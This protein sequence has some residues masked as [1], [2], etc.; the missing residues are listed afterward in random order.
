MG[1][2]DIKNPKKEVSPE[3]V[4]FSRMAARNRDIFQQAIPQQILRRQD[5]DQV[6]L[7]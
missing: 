3:V 7:K 5:S 1:D 6:R 4:A 2:R